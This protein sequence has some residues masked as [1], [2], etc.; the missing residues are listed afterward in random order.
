MKV[1]IWS[2]IVC[3][4]CYIGKRRLEAALV[5]FDQRDQVTITHHSFELAPQASSEEMDIYQVLAS[6]YRMSLDQAKAMTTNMADQA[7]QDGLTFKFETMKRSNTFDA[8]RLVHFAAKYGKDDKLIEELYKAYFTDSKHI[9]DHDTLEQLARSIGLKQQDVQDFLQDDLY[10]ED[11]RKDLQRARS[12]GING[13]PYFLIN[14][15]Y[16]ISG[17]QP[18]QVFIETLNQAWEDANS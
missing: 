16:E 3:P 17:A 12:L 14:D 2:D 6:K 4:F 13:V 5:E 8:H 7:A 9:G 1:D 10:A 18:V 15:K 11:V